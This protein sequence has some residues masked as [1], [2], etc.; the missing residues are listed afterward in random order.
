M[1]FLKKWSEQARTLLAQTS[2]ATRWAILSLLTVLLFVAAAMML[3]VGRADWVPIAAGDR[4]ADVIRRLEAESIPVKVVANRVTVPINRRDEAMAVL[5]QNDLLAPDT[6]QAFDDIISR[7]NIWDSNEKSRQNLMLAKQKVIGQIIRKMRGVRSADVMVSMPESSGFGAR[8]VRP[9]AS[10]NVVM[11]SSE[12]VNKRLVEAVARLVSGAFAE[13]RPENVVVVDANFGRSYT[14]ETED[15]A[16]AS[17]AIELV[18]QLEKRYREKIYETLAYIPGVI[19]AVNVRTDNVRSAQVERRELAESETVRETFTREKTQTSGGGGGEA[20]A[21]PNIGLSIEST[22]AAGSSSTEL[23]ER[24]LFGDKPVIST[25]RQTL[26][27]QTTQQINVTINVPRRYFESL[28]MRGKPEDQAPP[29][30]E[31]LTPF[32][33]AHLERIKAQVQPLI[34]AEEAGMVAAHMVPDPGTF[35]QVGRTAAAGS[36]V[37]NMLGSDGIKTIVLGALALLSIGVMF[38]LGRRGAA[39]PGMP[40][41]EEIAGL[42]PKLPGE[43]D[44]IGEAEESELGMSGVELDEEEIRARKIAEQISEMVKGNPQE[45]ANLI[46]K[47]V[48]TES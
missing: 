10:V 30:D 29:T 20:G 40:S 31:E 28:F 5:V 18:Q 7:Q 13:M 44:L 9:S 4:Q 24:T 23:E 33:E 8:A 43:E 34:S 14:V 41:A 12:P 38:M 39:G 45:A 1:D 21:R 42:P 2:V 17:E 22:A 35:E 3:W 25:T 36:G 47:W 19:V 32:A 26:V 15:N 27:G 16:T 11:E 48:R 46:R 37:L 6:S